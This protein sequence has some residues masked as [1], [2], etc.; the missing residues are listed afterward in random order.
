[1]NLRFITIL[2]LFLFQLTKGQ[3]KFY[4]NYD[5]NK[6]PVLT[7]PNEKIKGCDYYSVFEKHVLEYAY[8]SK[9]ELNLFETKHVI[10]HINNDKG[11]E[12][13]NKMY[14]PSSKII[15][16]IDLKARCITSS[17]KIINLDKNSVKQ[18]DNF[19]DNGPFTIFA[20]EG[21]EPNSD[22][23]FLY[24]SKKYVITYGSIDTQFSFPQENMEIDFISPSN[25][26]FEIK[27]YNGF[28]DFKKDTTDSNINHLVAI[29]K[30]V[31]EFVN[32]KYS[33][34]EA[35]RQRF[36]YNLRYN[37]GKSKAKLYTWNLIGNDLISSYYLNTKED[38]KAIS[39]AIDKS[40]A[41]K[42]KTD[43]DKII[44]FENYIKKNIIF[45]D[46]APKD[47]T[48]EK[49]LSQK[50]I[51]TYLLNRLFIEASKQLNINIETV[52]TNNKFNSE[53]DGTFEGYNQLSDVIIFYPSLGKYLMPANYFSRIGF[54]PSKN[55]NNKGLYLKSTEVSGVLAGI[56]KI[57]TIPYID[58]S[59]S[60]NTINAKISF[61][62]DDFTPKNEI[63][64]EFTGY[65]GYNIHPIY[66]LLND[67][68]KKEFAENILKQA[69]E[70]TVIKNYKVQNAE[71]ENI[72]R[73]PL[74]ISGVIETPMLIE[75]AGNKFLY[76]LGLII[77]PQAEL[78][79]E[80]A[81][82]NDVILENTHGFVRN[83]ELTIPENYKISNLKD[84]EFNIFLNEDNKETAYFKSSYKLEQNKLTINIS[85]Q[86]LSGVFSKLKYTE[87]K[88][89]INAAA[90]F[91]K[92]TLIFEKK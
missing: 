46:Q 79:Q 13:K 34:D 51:N 64:H 91:N 1:M 6:K 45:P 47:L 71:P 9:N 90:D 56:T 89:V 37:T 88:D 4:L 42:G 39:K 73:K 78:Y 27:S 44:E 61:E 36:D 55:L 38:E 84:L 35:T 49:A 32:E 60:Q 53:F 66:Y 83:I 68:Q 63:W 33:G 48:I 10:I 70:N 14:I 87:F 76:K 21:V 50:V 23:E 5:W 11:V 69:G 28:T 80:K 82:Q 31:G 19:E 92:I 8:D 25:L 86:Y 58:Y 74:I 17:G 29:A 20:F 2:F 59:L 12:L 77:G 75:K 57:K 22:I 15:E 7:I 81:R 41:L 52:F 30:N 67:E 26:V 54:I 40:G 62:G 43:L 16:M 3:T 65:S 85:E 72:F 18:V 24:T